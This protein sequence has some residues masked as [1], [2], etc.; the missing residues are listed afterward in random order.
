MTSPTVPADRPTSETRRAV[1]MRTVE[2]VSSQSPLMR[3]KACQKE[4]RQVPASSARRRG[5][6]WS[7]RRRWKQGASITR[8]E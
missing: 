1:R 6:R 2:L 7:A 8:R 5:L 4:R 3:A